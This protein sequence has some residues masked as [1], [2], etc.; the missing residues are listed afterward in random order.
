MQRKCLLNYRHYY[1]P[2]MDFIQTITFYS[3]FTSFLKQPLKIFYIAKDKQTKQLNV[4]CVK[5][6]NQCL[7]KLWMSLNDLMFLLYI[8]M[9][10]KEISN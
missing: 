9:V 1:V 6:F 3:F 4:Y 8:Y 7:Q 2:V 10:T 5:D